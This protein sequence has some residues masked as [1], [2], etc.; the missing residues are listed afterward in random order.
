MHIQ[1]T[2]VALRLALRFEV[3]QTSIKISDSKPTQYRQQDRPFADARSSLE[4]E[5]WRIN[6]PVPRLNQ[7]AHRKQDQ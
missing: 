6:G 1:S 3:E 7:R 2:R 4:S 5:Q